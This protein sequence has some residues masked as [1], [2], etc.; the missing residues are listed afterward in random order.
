L[1]FSS[2]DEEQA[3]DIAAA[4]HDSVC[5]SNLSTVRRTLEQLFLDTIDA[6]RTSEVDERSIAVAS[7][8]Q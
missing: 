3:A 7:S 1:L 6:T 4:I 8:L 2:T 5:A